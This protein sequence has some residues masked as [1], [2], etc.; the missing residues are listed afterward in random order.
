MTQNTKNVSPMSNQER[1]TYVIEHITD[2]MLD[3]LK[4]KS[5]EDISISELVDQAQVGRASFYRNY[6]SKE[7]VIKTFLDKMLL[8]VKKECDQNKGEPLNKIIRRVFLHFENNRSIYK[9]LNDRALTYL[10]KDTILDIFHLNS[11]CTKEEAYA[12]AAEAYTLYGWID[13]WFQRGMIE[14]ADEFLDLIKEN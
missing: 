8:K 5:I 12:R 14:S 4:H 11:E 6:R 2:A 9:L 3:L 13:V 1:N 10:I 7:D